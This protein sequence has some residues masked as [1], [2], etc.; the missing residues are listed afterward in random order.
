MSDRTSGVDDF[1]FCHQFQAK[2]GAQWIDRDLPV[3]P[4]VFFEGTDSVAVWKTTAAH[5]ITR[6]LRRNL[7]DKYRMRLVRALL[8]AIP[9]QTAGNCVGHCTEKR[10]EH[11][12]SE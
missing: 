1:R 5:S 8:P 2:D 7:I 11:T 3:I 12:I 9:G 10:A 4:S 6:F